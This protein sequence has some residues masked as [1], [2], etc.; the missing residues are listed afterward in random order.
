MLCIGPWTPRA[1]SWNK[2]MHELEANAN[3]LMIVKFCRNYVTPK[4]TEQHCFV[5]AVICQ[6]KI[7][8]YHTLQNWHSLSERKSMNVHSVAPW[9]KY[10]R[11]GRK[12]CKLKFTF[13]QTW[14]TWVSIDI[15]ES[16]KTPKLRTLSTIFMW[17]FPTL[18]WAI[19]I[20]QLL[21]SP[22]YNN[23]GFGFV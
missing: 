9:S 18:T 2:H 16:S 3:P 1:K 19:N 17:L 23:F 13:L 7:E 5:I 20:I 10:F 6:I 14:L 15:L 12:L 22:K 21:L 11:N 4:P 8:T